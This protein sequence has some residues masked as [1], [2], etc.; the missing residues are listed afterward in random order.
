MAALKLW[1]RWK[2]RFVRCTKRFS[3]KNNQEEQK[4]EVSD[5]HGFKSAKSCQINLT[6][7]R[8]TNLVATDGSRSKEGKNV[9]SVELSAPHVAIKR[10]P[11]ARLASEPERQI[12]DTSPELCVPRHYRSGSL[13]MDHSRSHNCFEGI[14]NLDLPTRRLL[15]IDIVEPVDFDKLKYEMLFGRGRPSYLRAIK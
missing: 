10:V 9:H 12:L 4:I 8:I 7:D 15:E 13:Q 14:R 3:S 2:S 1:K 11:R 6:A 5:K